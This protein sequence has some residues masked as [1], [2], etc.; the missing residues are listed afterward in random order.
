[1]RKC[2]IF[3]VASRLNT[4]C[5]PNEPLGRLRRQTQTRKS[6]VSR[7]GDE[8]Q[9]ATTPTPVQL[10][11]PQQSKPGATFSTAETHARMPQ[12]IQR[13]G[14]APTEI[15]TQYYSY[16]LAKLQ[17]S[18]RPTRWWVDAGPGDCR[19][20]RLRDGTLALKRRW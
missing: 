12:S 19:H 11:A 15:R 9:C 10:L 14:H 7:C 17:Q 3:N 5:E 2:V 6:P 13:I 18:Q 1:M 16:A 4:T 8:T 20:R